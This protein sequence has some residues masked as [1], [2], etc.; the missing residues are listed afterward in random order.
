METRLSI[1]DKVKKYVQFLDTPG[2]I[3]SLRSCTYGSR[4]LNVGPEK[5]T[6]T[7]QFPIGSVTK[8]F[9]GTTILQ[10][11]DEGLI[12][13][14]DAPISSVYIGVPNG[15]AITIRQ[16]G[17]MRSGLYNYSE[18][19]SDTIDSNLT[20]EWN[21]GELL[22]SGLTFAPYFRP[23]TGFHYSNTNAAILGGVLE[24]IYGS[25]I[26]EIFEDKMFK[27]IGLK[28]TYFGK[29]K[30][31]NYM[32]GY[33]YEDGKYITVDWSNRSWEF[34]AG[35][36]VSTVQDM[37]KYARNSISQ[38]ITLSKN[39]ARQQR[40]WQYEDPTLHGLTEKYGFH[41]AEVGSYVGHNGSTPGCSCSVFA[42]G[43]AKTTI[44]VVSAAQSNAHDLEIAKTITDYLISLLE[45][46]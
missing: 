12:P 5:I 7:T 39:A 1:Q 13:D 9:T 26:D 16:V 21:I 28:N 27:P 42:N 44:V 33:K 43:S 46:E 35:A 11:Y 15:D 4:D 24:R 18:G 20:R 31:G 29:L 25:R 10:A 6:T 19:L 45:N 37:H 40:Y 8:T 41:M 30:G 36:I 23:G 32:T 14:L 38:H 34:T 3:V 17:S 2:T 22:L